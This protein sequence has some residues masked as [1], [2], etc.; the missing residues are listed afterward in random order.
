MCILKSKCMKSSL[1]L[2]RI[3]IKDHGSAGSAI[4]HETFKE[5]DNEE[6]RNGSR[7]F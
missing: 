2:R 4:A 5:T 6:I 3:G 7:D 1:S